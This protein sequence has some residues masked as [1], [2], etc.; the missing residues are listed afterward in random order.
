M[1]GVR[2]I[3]KPRRHEAGGG[4]SSEESPAPGHVANTCSHFHS[5]L[6]HHAP[7]WIDFPEWKEYGAQVCLP[8]VGQ[9]VVFRED[10]TWAGHYTV[11]QEGWRDKS[12]NLLK[13]F[14]EKDAE[15]YAYYMDKWWDS[16]YAATIEWAFS[17]ALPLGQQDVM[18]K[19]VMNP[20]NGIKPYWMMMSLAQLVRELYDSPELQA[21]G[22]RTAQSAG[23][24]PTAYGSAFIGLI[25]MNSLFDPAPIRGGT[26]QLAHAS[27]RVIYENGGEIH[28]GQT[29]ENIIIENGVAKGIR[30]SDG[31]EIE[32]KLGVVCGANP[33]DL[34]HDLTDPAV[35]PGEIQKAVKNIERDFVTISWY[36]WAL[37]EQ[38]VY[39][40]EAF[41]PDIRNSCWINLSRKG[42]ESIEREA[43]LRLAGEWPDPE[44]FNLVVANWSMYEHDY[45]APPGG[46]STVLTEQFLQPAT[47]YSAEKW[48]EL[49]KRHADECVRFWNKYCENVTWD[50]VIGYVPVTPYYTAHHAPNYG[51]QGNWCVIDM[52]GTQVGRTRPIPQLADLRNFPIKNLYPASSAWHPAGAATSQQG[53]WVYQV[54]AEQH[55][56][57]KPPDKD[58]AGMVKK[59]LTD[60]IF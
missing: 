44:D 4:W 33:I 39:K 24:N 46:K 26:H 36:T 47:R 10:D 51:P 23:V 40:A 16:L 1:G 15:T 9:S 5:Y 6:Y 48:K 30:L 59:V 57:K 38:P 37:K 18:D 52:D 25:L 56:L 29:V 34:V 8:E 35:W 49:E 27:Q 3:S 32:A 12:Y 45:F 7:V 19:F 21:L 11:W 50:N 17:P 22:I 20:D 58:W 54:M 43:H 14:S 42:V 60:G 41:D 53:Y 31:T 2:G 55:S 13:R 28:H